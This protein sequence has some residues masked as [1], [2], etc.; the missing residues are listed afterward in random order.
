MIMDEDKRFDPLFTNLAWPGMDRRV[1]YV[2]GSI[3]LFF[4]LLK[5]AHARQ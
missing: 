1:L 2:Y 3:R 4:S 5:V